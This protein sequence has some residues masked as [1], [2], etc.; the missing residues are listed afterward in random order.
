MVCNLFYYCTVVILS[1]TGSR[2]IKFRE[3]GPITRTRTLQ[4]TD[5]CRSKPHLCNYYY[6]CFSSRYYII[7]FGNT[8][9]ANSVIQALYFCQPFRDKLLAYIHPDD[10]NETILSSLSDLFVQMSYSK[11]KFGVVQPKRFITRL[12]KENGK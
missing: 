9:Y 11:R 8:C 6:I 5:K 3:A 4:W 7:Q 10:A 2:H 1:Y 12:K